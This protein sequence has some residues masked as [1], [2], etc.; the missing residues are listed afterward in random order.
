M[1]P[2]WVKYSNIPYGSVGWRMGTGEG[3]LDSFKEWFKSR[4]RE[5][6]NAVMKAYNDHNDWEGFYTNLLN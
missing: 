2:P 4:D 6:Q 5:I 1:V 3:Y